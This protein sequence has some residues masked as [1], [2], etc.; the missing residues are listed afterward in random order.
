MRSDANEAHEKGKELDEEWRSGARYPP[1]SFVSY[2]GRVVS[3]FQGEPGL[4]EKSSFGNK[5]ESEIDTNIESNN[6]DRV[7][8]GKQLPEAKRSRTDCIDQEGKGES[9]IREAVFSSHV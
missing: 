9:M 5:L 8:G 2:G 1:P 7:E 6:F 4:V 3:D